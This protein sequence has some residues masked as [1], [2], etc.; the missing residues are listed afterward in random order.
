MLNW[1]NNKGEWKQ[2][3]RRRVNEILK[4]TR[5]S[6]WGYCNSEENPAEIGSRGVEAFELSEAKLWWNGPD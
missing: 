5:K 2:F 6:D 1:I 3:V 4:K